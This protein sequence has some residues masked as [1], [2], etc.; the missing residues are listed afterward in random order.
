MEHTTLGRTGLRVSR[1]GAGLAE[2]GDLS[3]GDEAA[4]SAVI[5][6]AA[7]DAGLSFLDTAACYGISEELI[8]KAVAHR[9]GEYVLATKCGHV[10]GD[11]EGEAWTR[12]TLEHSID[13]SLERLQTG[14]VDLLQ[15]HSCSVELLEEGIAID[16][17]R[18]AQEAGKTR[19][20][21]YSGDNAA[22]RWAV[23]SGIFDT[24]QTSFNL[25]DQRAH[26]TGLL[27]AARA[28]NMGIIVKRPIA[29]GAW[30]AASSPSP[31]SAEYFRR[32]QELREE[33]AIDAEPEDRILLAM[34]FTLAHPE[35]DT[36]IIG[37]QNPAH[38]RFNI[39]MVESRLPIDP[40]AVDALH[41]R[42][43]THDDDWMQQV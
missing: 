41:A 40:R 9:R 14:H 12:E 17:L 1:L 22:A 2:I 36:A 39:E 28:Q 27:A 19:F 10:A 23:D 4:A 43:D 34:G 38:M 13:R 33:G 30:G 26:S 31:Y 32:A 3:N 42:F 6:N 15:L 18:K 35:I 16:V 20:I 7:L 5:L 37:T 24:L 8:G 11:W 29:N 25:V 21:G